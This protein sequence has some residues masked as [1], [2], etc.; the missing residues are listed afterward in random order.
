MKLLFEREEPVYRERKRE[1][2][3]GRDWKNVGQK[4]E[5]RVNER[6][7]ERE[8]QPEGQ[9]HLLSITNPQLRPFQ[10]LLVYLLLI[11]LLCPCSA[12]NSYSPCFG[13]SLRS[14]FLHLSLQVNLVSV[15]TVTITVTVSTREASVSGESAG[16]PQF[17]P[18]LPLFSLSRCHPHY[19]E[20]VDEKGMNPHC[21]LRERTNENVRSL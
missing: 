2:I 20:V 3:E 12:D 21:K 6:W 16:Y 17:P 9:T 11:G 13:E 10:M 8:C 19:M 4:E 7:R 18:L 14:Y 1:L 5:E 15:G